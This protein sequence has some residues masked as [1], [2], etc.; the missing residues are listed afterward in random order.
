MAN[1]LTSNLYPPLVDT[2][3]PAFVRTQPCRIYFSLSDYNSESEIKEVH[4]SKY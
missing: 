2:F 1:T 4:I 3:M